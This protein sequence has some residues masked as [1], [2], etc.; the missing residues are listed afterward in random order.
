MIFIAS[1]GIKEVQ[2]QFT[3]RLHYS[4]IRMPKIKKVVYTKS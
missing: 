3:M 1:L 2:I 4:P